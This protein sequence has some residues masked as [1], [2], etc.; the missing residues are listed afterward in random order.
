MK[1]L[2]LFGFM[3]VIAIQASGPGENKLF[4]LS[5]HWGGFGGV[6]MQ[7]NPAG[8]FSLSGEGAWI[9]RNFYLGGFGLSSNY[10]D[11]YSSINDANYGAKRSSGGFMIGAFSNNDRLLSLFTE[12]KI[13]FGEVLLRREQAPNLFEEFESSINTI[14]PQLGIC[15]T[16]RDFFQIRLYGGYEHNSQ[17]ELIGIGNNELNGAVFGLGIYLGYF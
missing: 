5:N 8:N 9:F 6:N 1:K 2:I 13:G 4:S 16:P 14:T 11:L 12:V 17:F 7:I 3:A 15:L 10:G